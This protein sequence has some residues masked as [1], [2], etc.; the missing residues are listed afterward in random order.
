MGI[1]GRCCCTRLQQ[2]VGFTPVK[3]NIN[4]PLLYP[5]GT[6]AKKFALRGRLHFE[7]LTFPDLTREGGERAI[8][9]ALIMP[10]FFTDLSTSSITFSASPTQV[11]VWVTPWT[12]EYD[13]LC[14][15][16]SPPH[17]V[18][19]G[20]PSNFNRKRNSCHHHV[21]SVIV[22]S[23]DSFRHAVANFVSQQGVS[24]SPFIGYYVLE[25]LP[26]F[27]FFWVDSFLF[28][29]DLIYQETHS[30]LI[31][32]RLASS[33]YNLGLGRNSIQY[34]NLWTGDVFT[35]SLHIS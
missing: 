2:Y 8:P 10:Q 3:L 19:N 25:T 30:H 4:L 21:R 27:V 9:D 28:F 5:R 23:G 35:I 26:Q 34:P 14:L 33:S 6:A 7:Q 13:M 32:G 12:V 15:S 29:T 31:R 22:S 17:S 1:L 16:G 11:F 18:R 20:E 24:H